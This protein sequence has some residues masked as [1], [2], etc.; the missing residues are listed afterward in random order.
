MG[1][2]FL[3]RKKEQAAY[4]QQVQLRQKVQDAQRNLMTRMEE[5]EVRGSAGQGLVEVVLK[6]TGRLLSI[7]ISPEI[8]RPDDLEG[9]QDLIVAAVNDASI[10]LEAETEAITGPM[11]AS[12]GLSFA[13]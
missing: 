1:S 7:R 6:G 10:K 13:Y 8:V 4:Q 9:L 2:G 5:L 12:L 3:K 11:S